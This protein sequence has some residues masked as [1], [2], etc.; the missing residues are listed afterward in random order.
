MTEHP[1]PVINPTSG[2]DRSRATQF[3]PGHTGRPPGSVSASTAIRKELER[4]GF[5]WVEECVKRFRDPQLPNASRDYA[6]GLLVDRVAPKLKAVEVS[7][8]SGDHLQ[9]IMINIVAG[10]NPDNDPQTEPET[11]LVTK[12]ETIDVPLL[13]EPVT[14][15]DDEWGAIRRQ[16]KMAAD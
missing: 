15:V 3:Q 8:M 13:D 5:R 1:T 4:L 7:S 14:A 11:P 6:L 16:S 9:Q 2:V 12:D 10:V